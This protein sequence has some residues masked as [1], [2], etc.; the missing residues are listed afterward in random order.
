MFQP[1]TFR[2]L[3]AVIA[4]YC[5]LLLPALQWPGYLDS[6]AGLVVAV[7]YL[8]I[9]LFHGMGIPGLLQNN[10]LC[11]WGWC[12]PTVFGWVFL[13]LFWLLITWLLAWA[14]ASLVQKPQKGNHQ[15]KDHGF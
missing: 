2:F 1:R 14:A 7:P 8:S 13:C 5:L 3:A 11:G 6:P 9:Y 4:V 15:G 10:G 12:P